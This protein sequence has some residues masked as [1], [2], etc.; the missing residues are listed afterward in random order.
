MNCVQQSKQKPTPLLD[1]LTNLREQGQSPEWAKEGHGPPSVLQICSLAF[2]KL[3][4]MV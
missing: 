2:Y 4:C 3:V 1:P